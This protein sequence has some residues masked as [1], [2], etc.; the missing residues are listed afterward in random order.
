MTDHTIEQRLSREL[1]AGESLL[2][3]GQP[4]Q[5]LKLRPADALLIPFS[6][7]WGGFAFFWE[8]MVLKMGAPWFFA[9]WGVPFMLVGVYIIAGRFFWDARV[10]ART[11]YGVTDRRV[12][13]ISGVTR[14]HVR[15]VNLRTL[16]DISLRER[17]GGSGDVI[18]GSVPP[19]MA[20][21]AGSGWGFGSGQ[22]FAPTLELIPNARTIYEI[23]RQRQASPL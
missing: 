14:S 21:F 18:L 13:L 7:L 22:Q 6:V 15:S 8:F 16:G 23:I 1:D 11:Y 5:G 10:R 17:S 12:I 19:V 2:W 4:T 20:W 3:S 9:L